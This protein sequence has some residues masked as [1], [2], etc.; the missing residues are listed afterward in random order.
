MNR[1]ADKRKIR[2]ALKKGKRSAKTADELQRET[3]IENSRT[4]EPIR[5]MIRELIR[6]GLPV[7]SLPKCG[8]W[9]IKTEKELKEVVENLKSRTKGI[10]KRVKDIEKAF[11]T[12]YSNQ[13]NVI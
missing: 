9:I 4:Q 1:E 12:F 13:K 3:G 6:E 5:G 2:K 10:A 8:Y 7:G 11:E